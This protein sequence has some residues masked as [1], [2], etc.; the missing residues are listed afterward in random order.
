M[1]LHPK[2]TVNKMHRLSNVKIQFS[3]DVVVNH[4]VKVSFIYINKCVQNIKQ[5]KQT[6]PELIK[7]KI[8]EGQ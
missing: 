4:A 8:L 7:S 3:T 6:L 5:K 2:Q 1:C